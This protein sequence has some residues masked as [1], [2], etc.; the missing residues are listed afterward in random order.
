MSNQ[1]AGFVYSGRYSTERQRIAL[2]AMLLAHEHHSACVSMVSSSHYASAAAMLRPIG[3]ASACAF[4]TMY[5]APKKWLGSLLEL[6][7]GSALEFKADT[8]NLDDM[9]TALASSNIPGVKRL[10]ALRQDPMWRR[11]HKY[12]HGGMIQLDRRTHPQPFDES[13]N[14]IHLMQADAF[15][16]P[17]VSLG[18]V[19]F[20]SDELTSFIATSYRTLSEEVEAYG[21]APAPPWAGLPEPP[22]LD[23]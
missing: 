9:I 16:L 23:D 8:P 4:W 19:L 11:F 22:D 13:E 15:L 12:T 6:K 10:S 20:N 1:A 7:P 18:T 14:R 3:E 17:A 21:A 2:S 5:A